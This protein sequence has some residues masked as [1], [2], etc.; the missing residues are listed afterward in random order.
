MNQAQHESTKPGR[1]FGISGRFADVPAYQIG[2][3]LHHLVNT[4][5]GAVKTLSYKRADTHLQERAEAIALE[6]RA[7][8]DSI[9]GTAGDVVRAQAA[10]YE[11]VLRALVKISGWISDLPADEYSRI[12]PEC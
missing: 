8:A 5:A 3:D 2:N 1:E 7:L 6:A 11:E 9:R 12:F 4:L 10:L